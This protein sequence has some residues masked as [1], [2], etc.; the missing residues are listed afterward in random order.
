M[1]FLLEIPI[2]NDAFRYPDGTTDLDAVARRLELVAE[3]LRGGQFMRR[4]MDVN[5]NRIEMRCEI[6][7]DPRA[8]EGSSR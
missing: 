7:D 4:F 1:K 5:G 6:V 8:A 2:D 3:H